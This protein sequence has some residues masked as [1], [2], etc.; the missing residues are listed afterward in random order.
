MIPEILLTCGALVNVET[1]NALI[2]TES[3]YNPYAIA[4]VDGKPVKQPT[5]R[6]EAEQTIDVLE[7]K[8]LNYS[9]GLG[10][11]NKGNFEK[12][13]VTGKDLLDSCTNIKISEKILSQCY[14]DSP[15]NSVAEALSCYYSGN[16]SYG[17]VKEQ[18]GNERTAYVERVISNLN[19]EPKSDPIVP[20]IKGEAVQALAKVR[21]PRK[22]QSTNSQKKGA[23]VLSA[24]T[25][26]SKS[27]LIKNFPVELVSTENAKSAEKSSVFKF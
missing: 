4:V 3:H 9:V 18:V 5:T 16:Y 10:Q 2:Q 13:G 8:G 22:K 1:M 24:S 21:E 20:S 12:F 26:N 6:A 23:V 25:G 17:F 7:S 27:K 11:V 15:N 14:K 19:N